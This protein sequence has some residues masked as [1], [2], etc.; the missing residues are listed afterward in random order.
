MVILLY[1]KLVDEEQS[2]TLSSTF[3]YNIHANKVYFNDKV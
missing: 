1:E 2:E 3:F